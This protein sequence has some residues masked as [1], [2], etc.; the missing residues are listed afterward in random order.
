MI[1]VPIGGLL[2]LALT[3]S[4]QNNPDASPRAV[5]TVYALSMYGMTTSMSLVGFFLVGK[6]KKTRKTASLGLQP[7]QLHKRVALQ[8]TL[9]VRF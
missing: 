2:A 1:G 7:V 4:Y 6:R 8:P 3:S 5:Y 9:R